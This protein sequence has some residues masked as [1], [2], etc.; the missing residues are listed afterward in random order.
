MAI[1]ADS[2]G[3][4]RV[5]AAK[6]RGQRMQGS[7]DWRFA[8]V[9]VV[10]TNAAFI[11]LFKHSLILVVNRANVGVTTALNALTTVTLRRFAFVAIANAV[12]VR[13]EVWVKMLIGFG[14]LANLFNGGVH[15]PEHSADAGKVKRSQIHSV[16]DA[17]ALIVNREPAFVTLVHFDFNF[18]FVPLVIHVQTCQR[19]VIFPSLMQ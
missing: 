8:T 18:Q 13:P 7:A 19:S 4:F 6:W 1:V 12:T 2:R 3:V 11:A 5:N 9:A 15:L 10:A 14:N 17:Q 16:T